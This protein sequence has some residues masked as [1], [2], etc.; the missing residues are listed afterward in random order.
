LGGEHGGGR[1]ENANRAK[2]AG[3][4]KRAEGAE[5]AKRVESAENAESVDKLYYLIGK[6]TSTKPK[7]QVQYII[8][9]NS[10]NKSNN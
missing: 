7:H 3:N 5:N 9:D 6:H 1:T 4:A 2:H 10:R 8:H